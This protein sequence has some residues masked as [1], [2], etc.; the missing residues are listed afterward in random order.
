MKNTDICP[1]CNAPL[2]ETMPDHPDCYQCPECGEVFGVDEVE[3]TK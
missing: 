3:T 1:H 2:D